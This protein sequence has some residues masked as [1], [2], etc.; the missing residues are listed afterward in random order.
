MVRPPESSIRREALGS[1]QE[2]AGTLYFQQVTRRRAD[3]PG[4][5]DPALEVRLLGSLDVVVDGASVTIGGPRARALLSVLALEPGAVV[6]V[7]RLVETLWDG[8]APDG[9]TNAVQVYVSR[10]RKALG[11]AGAALQSAPGGYRLNL[12]PEAV[13]VGR[14]ER[15]ADRGRSMLATD[16]PAAAAALRDALGL[17]RGDALAELGPAADGLRAR[18][19]ARR[20]ATW[21]DRV[22]AELALAR[23]A[24]VLPEL[25]ELVRRHPLD[26]QLVCRLMTA[27][28]RCGRQADALAAHTAAASRLDDELGVDPGAEL[29]ALYQQVLRQ[30]VPPAPQQRPVPDPA[31]P[32]PAAPDPAAPAAPQVAIPPPR[33]AL[34]GRVADLETA[35]QRL[36]DPQVRALTLLGLGGTGKTRLAMELVRQWPPEQ[37]RVVA[38]AGVEDPSSVLPEICA[39]ASAV[40]SWAGE[41][42]VEVAVRALAGRPVLLLL[43]NLEQLLDPGRPGDGTP[44]VRAEQG[45]LADLE[46][47]LDR[48]PQLTL[49]C[50][51]RTRLQLAGEHVLPLGP[52]PVPPEGVTDPAQVLEYD[53]ARLFRDRAAAAMPGFDVTEQNAADVA[54]ACRLLDGLPLAL[55]L[56]AARIRMLPPS[57]I[58]RRSGARLGLVGGG[59]RTLPDR[60][61]SIR[62]ALDWSVALLD[63]DELAIFA[64]LSVFAGGW[65]LEAAEQVCAGPDLDQFEVLEVLGRLI[66][67]SLV[68]ADGSG[69]SWLLELVREYATELLAGQPDD[70]A[71]NAAAAHRDHYLALAERL[72]PAVRATHDQMTRAA[73]AAEAGNFAAAL[74]RVHGAGDGEQLTRLVVAL[75]DYWFYAG[76]LA[77]ADRWLAAAQ[78]ADVP[79][80]IRAQLHLSAGNL[81]LVGGDLTRAS[82]AFQAAHAAA[83]D[84][85]DYVLLARISAARGVVDRFRG[86]LDGAL[87]HL[88]VAE[89]MATLAGADPLVIRIGN[90]RGEVLGLLGQVSAAR[91]L[92]EGLRSWAI[93]ERSLGTVAMSTAQLALLAFIEG[94]RIVAMDLAG[95]ALADAERSGVT[96]VLGDVL[97]LNGLLRLRLDDPAGATDVLRR[98][99]QVNHEAA[100]LLSLPDTVSLL[101]AALVETG[102][103][104]AGVELIAIGQAWRIARGLA[105]GQPLAAEAITRAESVV[106]AGL[107][108]EVID[109]VHRTAGLTPFGSLGVLDLRTPATVIDLRA[110]PARRNAAD[111][112]GLGGAE[113]R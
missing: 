41:R 31:A 55:E 34:V 89:R 71:Q 60:H 66:D 107:S 64:R 10:L 17:W 6:S 25:E 36:A 45:W 48:L 62:A 75:L 19:E 104:R 109:A 78:A 27:L 93:G 113:V 72:V 56:A 35:L 85:G 67:K 53:A 29:R 38:L 21:I 65:T 76:A 18:L 111:R 63:P 26:E 49:L 33:S 112:A 79:G 20:L 42:A 97:T 100:Q 110:A 51:S 3:P 52:L 43:D 5:P 32:N 74:D 105:I 11:P 86:D 14:F 69:R 44:G 9:A 61:R 103:L 92:I 87:D 91:P 68:V 54:A 98:A 90:E 57:E 46:E 16:P 58:V 13:D 84:L 37:V 30:E 50:T 96:P 8:E 24:A 22:D 77:D 83:A 15:L 99:V 1:R 101:G 4:R 70:A 39:A 47:L 28:Y 80:Q 94:D 81:A 88:E 7:G 12:P 95:Q 82:T 59:G 40:P 108:A 102:D 23:H 73:L 2:S 106:A